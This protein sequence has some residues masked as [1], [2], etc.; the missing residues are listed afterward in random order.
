MGSIEWTAAMHQTPPSPYPITLVPV[1]S[2]APLAS[3]HPLFWASFAPFLPS[4]GTQSL[5]IA[6]CQRSQSTWYTS[7]NFLSW[8][9]SI[10]QQVFPAS[11]NLDNIMRWLCSNFQNIYW[12]SA[13]AYIFLSIHLAE[14]SMDASSKQS[15][16]REVI[17]KIYLAVIGGLLWRYM[18]FPSALSNSTSNSTL[19][20]NS[21]SNPQQCTQSSSIYMPSCSTNS[22]FR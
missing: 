16:V 12:S 19:H 15:S 10:F 9:C 14:G 20:L 18:T 13:S 7:C 5:V 22:V 6:F 11:L 1:L 3:F 4:T 21:L 8:N 17:Q 2:H